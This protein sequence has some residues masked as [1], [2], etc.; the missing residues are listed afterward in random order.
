M[1]E[2]DTHRHKDTECDPDPCFCLYVLHHRDR[3][4]YVERVVLQVAQERLWESQLVRA[5]CA[6]VDGEACQVLQRRED[7]WFVQ[8]A[9]ELQRHATVPHCALDR[10]CFW[11][12]I[13]FIRRLALW[14]TSWGSIVLYQAENIRERLQLREV[15]GEGVQQE[16][17]PVVLYSHTG[18]SAAGLH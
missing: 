5:V 8:W 18:R 4:S 12:A 13:V 10:F 1:I 11:V 9:H 3:R 17:A 7:L 6:S 15:R 16:R 14:R 2:E